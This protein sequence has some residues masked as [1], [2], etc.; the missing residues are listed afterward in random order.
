MAETLPSPTRFAL[1]DSVTGLAPPLPETGTTPPPRISHARGRVH[2]LRGV[3]DRFNALREAPWLEAPFGLYARLH[4][5]PTPPGRTGTGMAAPQPMSDC[6]AAKHAHRLQATAHALAHTL[7]PAAQGSTPVGNPAPGLSALADDDAAR[8]AIAALFGDG[9][10]ALALAQA[11]LQST[12]ALP[13]ADAFERRTAAVQAAAALRR[14]EPDPARALDAWSAMTGGDALAAQSGTAPAWRSFAAAPAAWSALAA[15]REARGATAPA[16]ALQVLWQASAELLALGRAAE[17]D[18]PAGWR[19][20]VAG[21]PETAAGCLGGG[22]ASHVLS[23]RVLA[24]AGQRLD[25]ADAA[26]DGPAAAAWAA[27]ASGFRTSGPGTP[28]NKATARLHKFTTWSRRAEQRPHSVFSAPARWFGLG[29][30]AAWGSRKLSPLSAMKWG[31]QGAALGTLAEEQAAHDAA[32]DAARAMLRTALA[33]RPDHAE[34]A[35][36][37]ARLDTLDLDALAALARRT[38]AHNERAACEAALARAR[39]HAQAAVPVPGAPLTIDVQRALARDALDARH[40][41]FAHH[42]QQGLALGAA[43]LFDTVLGSVGVWGGPLVTATHTRRALV[44]I[45]SYSMGSELFMGVDKSRQGSVGIAASA[46]AS[47]GPLLEGPLS[48]GAGVAVSGSPHDALHLEGA[49]L[50]AAKTAPRAKHQL[51]AVQDAIFDLAAR[52]RDGEA[53]DAGALWEALAP[54]LLANPDVSFGHLEGSE[55]SWRVGAGVSAGARV[56][57]GNIAFG[58]VLG[59]GIDHRR[60]RSSRADDQGA[61]RVSLA[62]RGRRTTAAV[63]AGL[64]GSGTLAL[65]GGGP[66]HELR[67]TA[68]LGGGAGLTLH[69]GGQQCQVR[70]ERPGGRVHAELVQ[71]QHD[72]VHRSDLIAYLRRERA[73]WAPA[74]GGDAAF[75]NVLQEIAELPAGATGGT[76]TW[77][78]RLQLR[79]EAARRLDHLLCLADTLAD[80]AGVDARALE[81]QVRDLLAD[82]AGW[83]PAQVASAESTPRMEDRGW[84]LF[85]VARTR[86]HAGSEKRYLL[87]ARASKPAAGAAT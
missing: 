73:A 15:V 18:T 59:A 70:M 56:G 61:L 36:E 25:D 50:R 43:V 9:T 32:R 60:H 68:A 42:G 17:H 41:V 39:A 8:A 4:Q 53:M 12:A 79:G 33:R 52:R 76:R 75:E 81:A 64:S 86:L 7:T 5:K 80:V 21:A 87:L 51:A 16:Q 55:K 35:H 63:T 29:V 22:E 38:L 69:L 49:V 28:F 58:P 2:P 83:E 27:W 74:L 54:A 11:L 65:A 71:A 85:L 1:S 40:A 34:A 10:D 82:P 23:C 77:T 48:G 26:L 20:F 67:L 3:V 47:F 13:A 62:Q 19:T 37:L 66:L 44:R 6:R 24:A 78:A 14:A 30:G 84:S 72:F 46:G 45:G 31:L 57:W